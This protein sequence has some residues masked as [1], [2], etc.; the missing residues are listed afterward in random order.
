MSNATFLSPRK[1]SALLIHGLVCPQTVP[2]ELPFPGGVMPRMLITIM[3]TVKPHANKYANNP[4]LLIGWG[5][6]MLLFF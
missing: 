5:I 1:P 2:Y 6:K 4:S 3:G